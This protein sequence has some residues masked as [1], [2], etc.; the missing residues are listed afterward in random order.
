MADRDSEKVRVARYRLGPA[1]HYRLGVYCEREEMSRQDAIGLAIKAFMRRWDE[2]FSD[3]N[4]TS[5]A[6]PAPSLI[7]GDYRA[8]IEDELLTRLSRCSDMTG[9][10]INRLIEAAVQMFLQDKVA[11]DRATL[12]K[13]TDTQEIKIG[14]PRGH[15]LELD[16][17][18]RARARPRS[19]LLE[20]LIKEHLE[21][22]E[23][24]YEEHPWALASPFPYTQTFSLHE[25]F[26]RLLF[27]VDL[28]THL[29][30]EQLAVREDVELED[31]YTSA[32]QVAIERAS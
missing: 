31:A 19:L 2:A 29:R 26:I 16:R 32:I 14:L 21:E 23:A 20:D 7:G 11:H 24:W 8:R 15:V 5:I 28:F 6:L 13:L 1:L 10:P 25:T 9:Y 22:L 12:P 17:L 18:S 27:N 30:M 3:I 4:T